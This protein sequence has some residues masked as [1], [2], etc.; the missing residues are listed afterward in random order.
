[1]LWAR[2]EQARHA[3]LKLKSTVSFPALASCA[4]VSL[5]SSPLAFSFIH[6]EV[7]TTEDKIAVFNLYF[8][9]PQLVRSVRGLARV[10]SSLLFI[11]DEAR[12]HMLSIYGLTC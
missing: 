7:F 6:L 9:D 2:K 3:Q 8:L 5:P 4:L 1:M 12:M 11:E 10:L